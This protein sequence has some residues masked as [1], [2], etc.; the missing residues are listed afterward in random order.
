MR[1]TLA[2]LACLL[3]QV[4]GFCDRKRYCQRGQACWPTESAIASF[5]EGLDP[6]AARLLRETPGQPQVSGVPTP[7]EGLEPGQ[8][9]QPLYGLGV[10]Q[11]DPLYVR[12][13]LN[14]T[15]QDDRTF[16]SAFCKAQVTN[17]PIYNKDPDFIAF[18]LTAAHVQRAVR[19]AKRHRLCVAV[20]GTGHEFNG[21]NQ[22]PCDGGSLL[23][24]TTLMMSKAADIT[25]AAG[26]GHASFT[27]GA[28]VAFAEAHQFAASHGRAIASG[29]CPTVGIVG[30]TLGGG[31]GPLSPGLGL[32]A[33]NLLA[34]DI[35]LASGQLVRASATEHT[36][37]YLALKGG[38][39]STWGV[40]TQVTVKAHPLPADGYTF[41]L[42]Q[43]LAG[44][45]CT[46]GKERFATLAT[47]WN[48][49][50]AARDSRTSVI[51]LY[52]YDMKHDGSCTNNTWSFQTYAVVVG[53][54]DSAPSLAVT[55]AMASL[56]FAPALAINVPHYYYVVASLPV[57]PVDSLVPWGGDPR[58]S[59]AL[60]AADQVEAM[61]ENVIAN[62]ETCRG[63]CRNIVM[64]TLTGL[65]GSPR[66]TDNSIS[67]S[68]RNSVAIY[69][70]YH[71]P[72][73]EMQEVFGKEVYFSESHPSITDIVASYWGVETYGRLVKTKRKYDRRNFFGCRNCVSTKKLRPE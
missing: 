57:Q 10:T 61:N 58:I 8:A 11:M 34:A 56:G 62:V 47:V 24:R 49:F 28:G 32:G 51:A 48:Q 37:L 42:G 55:E 52:L 43:P 21:R 50:A 29:S 41:L 15:C 3:A 1:C 27:F 38:G 7:V 72:Q 25:D 54:K 71:V 9:G 31:H 60:I 35:V 18:V 30:W 65:T 5:R 19:F 39:G 44:D 13:V 36:D 22:A 64:Y 67:A 2:V 53:A 40:V 73:T 20:A 12:E 33:D 70:N 68:L 45:F 26:L 63:T 14:A 46:E 6:E 66:P 23:I 59:S 69:L 4:Q 17:D 16:G